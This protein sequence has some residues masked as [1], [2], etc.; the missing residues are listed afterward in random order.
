MEVWIKDLAEFSNYSLSTLNNLIKKGLLVAS[1]KERRMTVK[2][3]SDNL[4][5]AK[6]ELKRLYNQSEKMRKA[7]LK[8]KLFE[9]SRYKVLEYF[10]SL[11]GYNFD[12]ETF[13]INGYKVIF[14]KYKEGDKSDFIGKRYFINNYD[15]YLDYY[16]PKFRGESILKPLLE[17]SKNNG[18]I[19]RN[20]SRKDY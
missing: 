5:K 8:A 11:W 20:E 19:E 10:C 18:G 17:N 9:S 16:L 14:R 3:Q 2:L 4:F 15:L 7:R 12:K 1:L 13:S 6:I